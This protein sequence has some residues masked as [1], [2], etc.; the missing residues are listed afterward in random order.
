MRARPARVAS[1]LLFLALAACGGRGIR[2]DSLFLEIHP[3]PLRRGESALVRV[4]APAD[5]DEVVGTVRVAGS[6]QLLFR[7]DEEV[8]LWYF[9]GVVPVSPWIRPGRYTVRV[10]VRREGQRDRY[11]EQEVELR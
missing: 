10:T 3:L 4:N 2:D 8:R 1:L 11:I 6:P 7:W 9:H 5:A